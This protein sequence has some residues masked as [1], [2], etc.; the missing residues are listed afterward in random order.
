MDARRVHRR[1]CTAPP[2]Q[3]S[4]ARVSRG[5]ARHLGSRS[6]A[7]RGRD[8][9][10][11]RVRYWT[12]AGAR[13][14]LLLGYDSDFGV[15]L[16][17]RYADGLHA[18]RQDLQT[19]ARDVELFRETA[20]AAGRDLQSLSISFR[21]AG[22]LTDAAQPARPLFVGSLEQWVD[23]IERLATLGV[24]HVFVQLHTPI[25][26]QLSTMTE[27]RE[28]IHQRRLVGGPRQIA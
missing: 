28:R 10:H 6:R 13:D 1:R 23:D 2:P 14:S 22:R 15:R 24:S 17:A 4:H 21:G 11:S 27:L 3:A 16:A 19:F 9:R 20:V 12:E 25:E 18:N 8:L 26:Q 7:L 5:N